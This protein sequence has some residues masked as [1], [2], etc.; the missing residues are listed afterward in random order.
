MVGECKRLY[1]DACYCVMRDAWRALHWLHSDKEN[2]RGAV[3]H[4]DL[5]PANILL[6]E[7]MRAKVRFTLLS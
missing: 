6:D 4:F 5:K 3:L 1:W 2:S 7:S